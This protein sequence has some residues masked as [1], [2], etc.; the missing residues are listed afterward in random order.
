MPSRLATRILKASTV[1]VAEAER[2]A[3]FSAVLLV[4]QAFVFVAAGAVRCGGLNI[5]DFMGAR[6]T[7]RTSCEALAIT[8][9]TARNAAAMNA[10]IT[11]ESGLQSNATLS[12]KERHYCVGYRDKTKEGVKDKRRISIFHSRKN[13]PE[14][15]RSR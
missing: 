9:S 12:K 15:R 3:L 11:L 4:L 14:Q 13:R 1:L 10:R 7:K 6:I 2:I 5:S 8:E